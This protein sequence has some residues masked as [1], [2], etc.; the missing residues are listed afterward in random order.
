[1]VNIK[2]KLKNIKKTTTLTFQ[3]EQSVSHFLLSAQR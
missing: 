3:P 1:V 2:Q